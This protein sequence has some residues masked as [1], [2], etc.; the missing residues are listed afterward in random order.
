[1][2]AVRRARRSSW[3]SERGAELVE[4]ALTL[5]MLLLISLGIIDFGLMFQ[6]YQVITNAAREGA[7]IA[8][9]SDSY[10]CTDAIARTQAYVSAG[11]LST[12]SPP[13]TVT[14][15]NAATLSFNG[16]TA[17]VATVNVSYVHSYSF[18]GGIARLLGS[19]LASTTLQA[20]ATIR[21]EAPAAP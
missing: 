18:V 5:P 9:L 11:G 12:A 7:R 10:T 2:A 21:K 4:F 8:G 3:R 19:T 16:V 6:Q 13:L 15:D 14:C 1:M 17:A 20:T